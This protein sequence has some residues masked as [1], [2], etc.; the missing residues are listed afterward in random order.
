[1][2]ANTPSISILMI[3]LTDLCVKKNNNGLLKF[4]QDKQHINFIVIMG[5]VSKMCLSK[6]YNA[7]RCLREFY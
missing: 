2:N 4:A 7:E 3:F 1:M 6:A 5:L